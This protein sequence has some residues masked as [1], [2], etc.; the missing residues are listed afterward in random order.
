M[1]ELILPDDHSLH[2][3]DISLST[4]C[5]PGI[6]ASNLPVHSI[7]QCTVQGK[8]GDAMKERSAS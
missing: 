7:T 4:P 6:T 1:L 8:K 3:H 5:E 2:V